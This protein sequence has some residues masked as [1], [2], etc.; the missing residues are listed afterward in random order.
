MF[1]NV[2]S[3]KN[4]KNFFFLFCP[5]SM[6]EDAVNVCSQEKKLHFESWSIAIKIAIDHNFNAEIGKITSKNKNHVNLL[7]VV[8]L[9]M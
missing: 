4:N 6:H 2:N 5:R 9:F 1:N 8:N 7:F 3:P